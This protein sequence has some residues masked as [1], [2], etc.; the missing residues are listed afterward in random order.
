LA[1]LVDCLGAV[2][3]IVFVGRAG[4]AGRRVEVVAGLSRFGNFLGY[5]W[6]WVLSHGYPVPRLLQCIPGARWWR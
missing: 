5:C 6:R 2:D 1:P 4:F 3:G